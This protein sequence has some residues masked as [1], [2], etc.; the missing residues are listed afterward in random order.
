MHGDEQTMGTC[1]FAVNNAMPHLNVSGPNNA[2]ADY[3]NWGY[4]GHCNVTM[5]PSWLSW[6]VCMYATHPLGFLPPPPHRCP[7]PK[8]PYPLV[9][10]LR[11]H[12]RH[13]CQSEGRGSWQ[14]ISLINSPPAWSINLSFRLHRK[15]AAAIK[16]KGWEGK[17]CQEELGV[18][19]GRM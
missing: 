19:K 9:S 12:Y 16:T 10:A 1:W 3:A 5:A 6:A 4:R 7:S 13:C 15:D 2:K 11:P 14:R 17:E 8:T 18:R